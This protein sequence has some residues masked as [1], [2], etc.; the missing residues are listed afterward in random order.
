MKEMKTT[1]QTLKEDLSKA[2]SKCDL[3]LQYREKEIKTKIATKKR[4]NAQLRQNI[5]KEKERVVE[6]RQREETVFAKI[7]SYLSTEQN[8]LKTKQMKWNVSIWNISFLCTK[9]FAFCIIVCA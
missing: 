4:I 7:L 2:K 8:N 9:R 3:N 6:L 1:I 5:Q